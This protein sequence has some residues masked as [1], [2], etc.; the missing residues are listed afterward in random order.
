MSEGGPVHVV[1]NRELCVGA[2]MCVLT[3]PELFDQSEEDG[4]VVLV[5]TP[6]PAEAQTL[7]TVVPLCPSGAIAL[8]GDRPT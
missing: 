7:R 6:D 8:A 2:G 4:L 1:V 5:R 3:A